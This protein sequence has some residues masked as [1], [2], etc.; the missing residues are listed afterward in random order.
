LEAQNKLRAEIDEAVRRND[1][2]LD[3]Q[4]IH[5]LPYL[6]MALNGTTMAESSLRVSLMYSL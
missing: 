1:G 4:L 2:K 3:Y 6:D 5:D